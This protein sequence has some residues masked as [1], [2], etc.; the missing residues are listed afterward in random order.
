MAFSFASDNSLRDRGRLPSRHSAADQLIE[1]FMACITPDTTMDAIQSMDLA[2]D[3]PVLGSALFRRALVVAA[4]QSNNSGLATNLI[5]HNPPVSPPPWQSLFDE[6][7]LPSEL[8]DDRSSS[9][10]V[11]AALVEAD[12]MLPSRNTASIAACSHDGE[13]G[14]ALFKAMRHAGCISWLNHPID[15]KILPE[16]ALRLSTPSLLYY[17]HDAYVIREPPTPDMLVKAIESRTN[18]GIEMLTWLLEQG[19]D[20]NYISPG[21]PLV[22]TSRDLAEEQMMLMAGP[23]TN[24]KTALHAAAYKGNM[25]AVRF[26]LQKGADP[27]LEDGIGQTAETVAR[28]GGHLLVAEVLRSKREARA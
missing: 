28:R 25:E 3:T 22:G 7:L 2:S 13:A 9:A 24:V 21:S 20:V 14:I 17:I 8:E 26:L 12:W 18:G 27:L 16:L 11:C 23:G 5:E 19:I 1:M 10:R 4:I 15:Q 6:S